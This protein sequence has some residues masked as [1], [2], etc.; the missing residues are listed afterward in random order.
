MYIIVVTMKHLCEQDMEVKWMRNCLCIGNLFHSPI[1][2]LTD[3]EKN[4]GLSQ[5]LYALNLP[6]SV[7]KRNISLLILAECW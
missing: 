1:A 7:A 4:N 3:I 6:S 5:M 2:N